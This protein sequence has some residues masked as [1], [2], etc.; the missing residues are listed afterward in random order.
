MSDWSGNIIRG[1]KSLGNDAVHLTKSLGS[2]LNLSRCIPTLSG[3]KDN[4]VDGTK[5][6]GNGVVNVTKDISI[7]AKNLGIITKEVL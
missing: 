4:V 3:W 5:S 2:T 7:K 1:T 6:L